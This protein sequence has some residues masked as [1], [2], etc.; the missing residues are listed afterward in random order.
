MNEH[1]D[2]RARL[3]KITAR[4]RQ[5]ANIWQDNCVF[6]SLHAPVTILD[7]REL[8]FRLLLPLPLPAVQSDARA[9]DCHMRVLRALGSV[10]VVVVVVKVAVE[11]LL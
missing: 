7:N 2:A 5:R 10:V 3:P 9:R 1:D 11:C 6:E 8:E 4:T